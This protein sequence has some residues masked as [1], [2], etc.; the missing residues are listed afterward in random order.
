M[1]KQRR[2]FCVG[3]HDDEPAETVEKNDDEKSA[4]KSAEKPEKSTEEKPEKCDETPDKSDRS[5]KDKSD[6]SAQSETGEQPDQTDKSETAAETSDSATD[7]ELILALRKDIEQLKQENEKL[8]VRARAGRRCL[9]SLSLATTGQFLRCQAIGRRAHQ[10][11]GDVGRSATPATAHARLQEAQHDT[12]HQS[13]AA[14]VGARRL[15]PLTVVGHAQGKSVKSAELLKKSG[16]GNQSQA[17][18]IAAIRGGVKVS[19][20]AVARASP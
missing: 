18:I 5:E 2:W 10:P 6:N 15:S 16:G 11:A 3:K 19:A 12:G 7:K 1:L 13:T 9:D 14:L 17:E 4:E 8:T 20:T